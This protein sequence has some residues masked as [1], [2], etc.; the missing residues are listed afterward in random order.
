MNVDGNG[1]IRSSKSSIKRRAPTAPHISQNNNNPVSIFMIIDVVEEFSLQTMFTLSSADLN[2]PHRSDSEIHI[3][4]QIQSSN[5]KYPTEV[6]TQDTTASCD[7]DGHIFVYEQH[8]PHNHVEPSGKL[9][10][11]ILLVQSIL[12]S[13]I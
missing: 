4:I 1:S 11:F 7:D 3:P 8:P 10:M 9:K 6:V 2:I 12:L 13:F 5:E